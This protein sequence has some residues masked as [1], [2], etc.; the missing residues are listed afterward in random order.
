MMKCGCRILENEEELGYE[1]EL[2]D[3]HY[4]ELLKDVTEKDW[5]VQ[6]YHHN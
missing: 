6:F 2:C 3:K 5:H 1:A 4:Q